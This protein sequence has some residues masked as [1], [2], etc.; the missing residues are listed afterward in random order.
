[1]LVEEADREKGQKLCDK[2]YMDLQ[3]I[4]TGYIEGEDELMLILEADCRVG[5]RGHVRVNM[6]C[7][8]LTAE[9]VTCSCDD[10]RQYGYFYWKA[11]NN[12]KYVAATLLAAGEIIEK[13]NIGD[14]TDKTG[15]VLLNLYRMQRGKG[16]PNCAASSKL[17][18]A[19]K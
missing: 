12:C 7:S 9:K 18:S 2:G 11:E 17:I 1:M 16:I 5:S 19:G 13:K 10:C 15:A 6:L 8:K 3:T 14:A 4:D